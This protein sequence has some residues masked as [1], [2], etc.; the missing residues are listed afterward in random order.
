MAQGSKQRRPALLP[1]GVLRRCL[2]ADHPHPWISRRLCI[3]PL[4]Y[5]AGH[6][7]AVRR[8][9]GNLECCGCGSRGGRNAVVLPEGRRQRRRLSQAAPRQLR[10]SGAGGLRFIGGLSPGVRMGGQSGAA[11]GMGAHTAAD[12]VRHGG[13]KTAGVTV[14]VWDAAG[15][16][17][18][19]RRRY[20][21]SSGG[22]F[23][24]GNR[25]KSSRRAGSIAV[26]RVARPS[27]SRIFRLRLGLFYEC[28]FYRVTPSLKMARLCLSKA[29]D[30]A[31]SSP[32]ASAS[33]YR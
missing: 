9:S 3:K 7:C 4:S 31:R 5:G 21:A 14:S 28:N 20:H 12:T 6:P 27:R 32:E 23:A 33:T 18:V 8:C 11:L 15:K 25:R 2:P 13:N 16:L 1:D 19:Q 24:G 26:N 22:A 10:L 30:F 29:S 17:C